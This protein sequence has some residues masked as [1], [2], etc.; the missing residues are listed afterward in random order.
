MVCD[1][2]LHMRP[3]FGTCWI[4]QRMGTARHSAPYRNMCRSCLSCPSVQAASLAELSVLN[5]LT[6]LR[7]LHLET[8]LADGRLEH[9]KLGANVTVNTLGIRGQ[10]CA[11]NLAACC[12][13]CP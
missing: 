4:Q 12:T 1:G 9:L 10:I 3:A 5:P 13:E 2:W 8:S 6:R 7:R 11:C